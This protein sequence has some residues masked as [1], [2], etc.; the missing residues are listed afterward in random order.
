M[1]HIPVLLD[2]VM[3]YL[4][5]IEN[6][7]VIVDATLGLGGYSERILSRY[8]K[9]LILGIDQ[10]TR[11]LQKAKERLEG[12]NERILFHHGNF[13]DLKSIADCHKL[14]ADAVVMDLGV[15][16]MQ[17]VDEAR[18]FSYMKE[19]PLDMRMDQR[20]K[21]ATSPTA[22]EV[23][24][25]SSEK[26]LEDIFRIYGEERYARL[27]SRGIVEY[28]NRRGS[29]DTTTQLVESIRESLPQP[30]QRK[31]GK[32]PAR[33]V[34]QA[35]RI[36]VNRELESLE[37][38]L[39]G[40]LDICEKGGLIIVIS[41]HSLE[42]RIVKTQFREWKAEKIGEIRTK[43][44]IKPTEQEIEGNYKARSAKLRVFRKAS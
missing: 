9:T 25:S 28:R 30:V 43:K 23:V 41:Y 22:A 10:D 6:P 40:A 32:H 1:E 5:S 39:R 14:V 42:D 18:G 36:F 24:N 37:K 15:S 11:A 7:Q 16:N 12:F 4:E 33:R 31:M 34:F 26:E 21:G 8:N 17:L 38:G 35:L 29:I 19:G 2:R 27:I 13:S 20:S 3:E 44:P